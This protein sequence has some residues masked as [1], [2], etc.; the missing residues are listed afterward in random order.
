MIFRLKIFAYGSLAIV[1]LMAIYAFTTQS[2][3]KVSKENKEYTINNTWE[4]PDV[5]DEISGISWLK[6]GT[7]ASVQDEDGIIF[8]YNLKQ[9]KIVERIEFAGSGD[10]E[11]IAVNNNDAYVLR[12]DGTIYEISNFRSKS[13]TVQTF[14]TD[15]SA[16]NNLESL[17]LNSKN[18]SLIIAPKDR[19]IKD[20]FKGLY[21]IPITSKSMDA[22]PQIK[23]NMNDGAFNSYK[24]KKAYKTFSPSDIAIHPKTGKYYILDGKNPK[25]LILDKDG[26]IEKVYKLDK[27]QFAQ[28][29]GITF[30]P[31]GTLYISNESGNNPASILQVNFK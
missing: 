24:K 6:D 14:K 27:N 16:K 20:D 10:Y 28:P 3:Y 31:D 22:T 29:E 11:G 19:D 9:N 15:F 12:S 25:L 1:V 23:I 30:S 4:L 21:Q 5:L 17:T 2:M 26:T 13:R 8:I 7:I 18:N